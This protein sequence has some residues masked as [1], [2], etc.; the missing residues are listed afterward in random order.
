MRFDFVDR[1]AILA[2]SLGCVESLIRCLDQSIGG[3]YSAFGQRG[4][5]EARRHPPA[6]SKLAGAQGVTDA[7]GIE[8]STGLGGLDEQD[9]EPITAIAA[10]EVTGARMLEQYLGHAT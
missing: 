6:M 8:P 9:R 2:G 4:D 3:W 10:G 5:A 7:V 1:D